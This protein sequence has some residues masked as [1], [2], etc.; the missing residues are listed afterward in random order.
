MCWRHS[1]PA[2]EWFLQRPD[3][4]VFQRQGWSRRRG[5]CAVSKFRCIDS[6]CISRIFRPVSNNTYRTT[7]Y[8]CGVV[9]FWCHSFCRQR[10]GSGG[11]DE[12]FIGISQPC[13]CRFPW[14]GLFL[15]PPT[16]FLFGFQDMVPYALVRVLFASSTTR[17]VS[18]FFMSC[19][20]DGY[21]FSIQSQFNLAER[22]VELGRIWHP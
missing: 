10:C 21:V 8:S 3:L 1:L 13:H 9:G 19:N 16:N 17:F 4:R 11:I 5:R 22:W 12:V 20:N 6:C 15:T 7:D 14:L 2:E 18:D